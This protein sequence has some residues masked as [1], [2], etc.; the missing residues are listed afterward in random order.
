MYSSQD[1]TSPV[2]KGKYQVQ[3]WFNQAEEMVS[4]ESCNENRK[5][6]QNLSVMKSIFVHTLVEDIYEAVLIWYASFYA[7]VSTVVRI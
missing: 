2:I 6:F 1:E 3:E 7:F 5:I 4:V